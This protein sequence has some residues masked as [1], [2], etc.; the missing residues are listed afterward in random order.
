[1]AR[2]F[3][4]ALALL[5]AW[6]G[7]ASAAD[8]EAQ[9]TAFRK[10]ILEAESGNWAG[11]EPWLPQLEGYVLWPDLR[12]G[13]LRSRLGRVPDAE[14]AD[15]LAAYPD[16][17]VS[18]G[19]RKAWAESLARRG[20]WETFL[21]VYDAHLAADDATDLHCNALEGRI[22]IGRLEGVTADAI[23]TWLSPYSQPKACDPVF[24]WLRETGALSEAHAA[25]RISLALEAGQFRLARYLA[26]SASASERTRVET[27]AGMHA[28]P[29]RRLNG[30]ARSGSEDE[31][32]ALYGLKR[33]ASRDPRRAV[34]MWEQF[35]DRL[36]FEGA[37]ADAVQRRIAL[38]HA[39]RHLPEGRDL[40]A[41]LPDSAVDEDVRVWRFRLALR[42]LD[43][44]RAAD[45]LSD[46]PEGIDGDVDGRLFWQAR[47]MEAAGDA[48]GARTIYAEL[49]GHRGY[50]AF[51]AADRIGADYQWRHAEAV[52]N[53]AI[54][55][56]LESRQD[57]MRAR[58]FFFT[59]FNYRGRREWRRALSAMDEAEKTQASILAHR[60]GWHSRAIATASGNGLEDDLEIRFPLPW[61]QDFEQKS[62]AA[63]IPT[64]W[65]YGIA[66]SE[67]LF[68]PDVASHAG[69]VG[70][71]Q[72]M[73]ETGRRTA[74]AAKIPY[75]GV[76]TLKDPAANIT[77]GTRYL[78]DMLNR[79]GQHR[80]LATA[81]YNAGPHRVER[82][83][84]RGQPLPA[85]VWVET[86]PYS[87]TRG[88]VRR[89]LAAEAVFHWRMNEKTRRLA[90]A[91][92][93]VA[94]AG[95]G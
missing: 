24:A 36:G 93:P 30:L 14:V 45:Y 71:M 64:P 52:A 72:L 56:Q 17:G 46:L 9:R 48:D 15:F 37:T 16:L 87:E 28:D 85:D 44:S 54:I 22:R 41:E 58:E 25:Q 29:A 68:M 5:L 3:H 50:H 40:L 1:M 89:V 73:P 34:R 57:V 61:R 21:E 39:W 67:S 23:A 86:V 26:R 90:E 83:L 7:T 32:L 8:L 53:E 33:L 75:R 95:G 2:C 62:R 88:Y 63:R 78:G 77:L 49:A 47:A 80:V 66:R 20:R 19:L 27:W 10:A 81:A 92:P 60:W 13:W 84:P 11:V 6:S 38:I 35:D 18:D 55:Q 51:L 69:A 82:W 76:T 43:W 74:R 31:A 4:W 42:D 79:F 59:G 65:A 94:P 91:M 12:A 70:L